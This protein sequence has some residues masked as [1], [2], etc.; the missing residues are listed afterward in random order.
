MLKFH[1]DIFGQ[2]AL[3]NKMSVP[4]SPH[5]WTAPKPHFWVLKIMTDTRTCSTNCH[6]IKLHHC[7]S[8]VY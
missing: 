7:F 3:G 4:E 1:S 5:K 8:C 2:P 6:S